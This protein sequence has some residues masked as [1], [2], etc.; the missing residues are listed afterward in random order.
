MSDTGHDDSEPTTDTDTATDTTDD[1]DCSRCDDD[2]V[3]V[4]EGPFWRGC[5]PSRFDAC[6]PATL[7]YHEVWLDAFEIDR[8]EVTQGQ[9]LRCYEA[10]VCPENTVVSPDH[11]LFTC[12]PTDSEPL[13]LPAVCVSWDGALNRNA[14]IA[15]QCVP[16]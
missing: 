11:H 1:T 6:D 8:F 3:P 4:P 7:P 9:Y 10:G 13:R 2:M 16:V 15:D 5:D 12:R 14:L